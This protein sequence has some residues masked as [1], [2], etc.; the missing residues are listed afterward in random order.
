[1]EIFNQNQVGYNTDSDIK[2]AARIG[3]TA[4]AIN[5]TAIGANIAESCNKAI[6]CRLEGTMSVISTIQP[7]YQKTS[8]AT[9]GIAVGYYG[10]FTGS[11][12][13]SFSI[14]TG[15]CSKSIAF[16]CFSGSY[17]ATGLHNI[18]TSIATG[19]C[20]KPIAIDCFI[21]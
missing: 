15:P 18:S 7:S 12:N 4:Q 9:T 10:N 21:G 2:L 19:P 8:V 1:M 11:N 6:L 17:C 14:R 16:D 5:S 3:L 13:N 20:S